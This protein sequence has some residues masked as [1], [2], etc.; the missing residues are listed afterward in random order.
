M[1]NK[2]NNQQIATK[3]AFLFMLPVT[4]LFSVFFLSQVRPQILAEQS[5]TG[6]VYVCHI[7]NRN[8]ILGL[9]DYQILEDSDSG[10]DGGGN[11]D[12][13]SHTYPANPKPGETIIARDIIGIT[14]MDGNGILEAA[15]CYCVATNGASSPTCT[16]KPASSSSASSESSVTSDSSESSISSESSVSST[17]SE[18]S[19]ES[20]V[21]SSSS[22]TSIATSVET[23]V[24]TSATTTTTTAFSTYIPQ[25]EI[26]GVT[27]APNTAVDNRSSLYDTGS[28]N[29]FMQIIDWLAK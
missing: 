21:S 28:K 10:S 3:V 8:S 26:L 27:D 23:S 13:T 25:P 18:Y 24:S 15:D 1:S 4:V 16:N 20:S 7:V 22:I 12:H 29:I 14:D 19:S 2:Q 6:R 17:T 11:N 9:Y 5:G